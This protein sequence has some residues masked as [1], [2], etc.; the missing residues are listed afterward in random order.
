MF[1]EVTQVVFQIFSL[2]LSGDLQSPYI[3]SEFSIQIHF[4]LQ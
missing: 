1:L 4:G 2:E 3:S